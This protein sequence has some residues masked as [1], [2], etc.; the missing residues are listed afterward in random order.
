MIYADSDGEK[1]E[2][3]GDKAKNGIDNQRGAVVFP[4]LTAPGVCLAPTLEA[5]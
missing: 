2:I 3:A 4:R 1:R 5:P